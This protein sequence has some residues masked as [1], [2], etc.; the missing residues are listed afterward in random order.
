MSNIF[1]FRP[2]EPNPVQNVFADW[3]L[4]I[5]GMSQVEGRK[6]LEFDDSIAEVQIPAGEWPM[7]DVVWAGFGPRPPPAPG[8]TPGPNTRVNILD[9]ASFTGLRVIGGQITIVNKATSVSPVA[10]FV[11]DRTGS[12]N[13]VQI[14][15]RD[16]CGN[17]QIV[18]QG[19]AP[20]FD[21]KENSA[22]FWVQ[23]CRFGIPPPD[24]SVSDIQPLITHTGPSTLTINLLGQN[25]T[26]PNVVQ[27]NAGAQVKF[28]IVS[29]AAQVAADQQKIKLGGTISFGPVGRIQRRVLPLP[30][31]PAAVSSL[32]ISDD[33]TKP[34]ALIRCNGSGAGFTQLLPKVVGGFTV[35]LSSIPLYSGGQEIVVAE[36]DGGENL[37]VAPSAGDTIDGHAGEVRIGAHGSRTFVS[38]GESNWITTSVVR[39]GIVPFE[40]RTDSVNFVRDHGSG[41]RTET[42]DIVFPRNVVRATAVLTGADF[43]FSPRNDHHLGM[44]NLKVEVL[45][46]GNAVRVTATLGVRDWS[47]DWDDDYEGTVY[48]AVLAELA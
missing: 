4:L 20:M 10:D 14:G 29:D 48:F 24:I 1:V 17:S 8:Q 21:L 22:T 46:L 44:V 25:Q 18:N 3:P 37:A 47:N 28:G 23:N 31:S 33:L 26:G 6:L 38:D 7:K 39:P 42:K 30:P 19:T 11:S 43:G 45:S 15:L 41:P 27:S 13:H 12:I 35:G 34:N 36:V 40:I 16:D 32:G 2:G 9:G 5:N